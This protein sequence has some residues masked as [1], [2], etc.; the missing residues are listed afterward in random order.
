MQLVN[1]VALWRNGNQTFKILIVTSQ[2]DI[3]R[4]RSRVASD[5]AATFKGIFLNHAIFKHLNYADVG[6]RE[7]SVRNSDFFDI[8]LGGPSFLLR[9]V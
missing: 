3:L 1:H 4:K 6:T 2:R 8:W 5:S 7:S 9:R